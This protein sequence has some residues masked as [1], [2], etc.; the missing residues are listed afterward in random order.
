MACPNSGALRPRQGGTPKTTACSGHGTCY[1]LREL[2]TLAKDE[3]GNSLS[4]PF[5]AD[6]DADKIQG[7]ECNTY[8][9]VGPYAGNFAHWT[10]PQCS[11][12]ECQKGASQYW[13]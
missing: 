7:C 2:A 9:Y 5:V 3:L 6:W 1:T 12:L 13:C 10:G 4:V 11:L 8:E